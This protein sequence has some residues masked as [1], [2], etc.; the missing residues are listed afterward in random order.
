VWEDKSLDYIKDL[1]IDLENDPSVLERPGINVDF[2]WGGSVTAFQQGSVGRREIKALEYL[3][4]I[5][6]T[7]FKGDKDSGQKA[8]DYTLKRWGTT[9]SQF[10]KD[11][12]ELAP[13]EKRDHFKAIYNDKNELI[14]IKEEKDIR[15]QNIPLLPLT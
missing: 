5:A 13:T 6:E 1:K 4:N 3:I 12:E 15:T 9:F 7:K 11:T 2:L 10:V 14:L 8:I